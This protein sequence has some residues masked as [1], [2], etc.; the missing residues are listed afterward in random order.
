MF[1]AADTFAADIRPSLLTHFKRE[2]DATLERGKLDEELARLS[3]LVDHLRPGSLVLLNES[4]AST[5]EREGSGIGRQVIHALV[6]AGVKVALVT[7][8]FDLADSLRSKGSGDAVFLR[9]ERRSDGE[10]TF[11]LVPGDPQP[12]SHG[13]DIF[14]RVF[15]SGDG[16]GMPDGPATAMPDWLTP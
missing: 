14:W 8:L 1:V 3:G 11:R 4:F 13:E 12:T 6:E 10:R 15:G 9:A 7:H 2:E 16:S 5:N